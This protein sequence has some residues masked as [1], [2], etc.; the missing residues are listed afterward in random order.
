MLKTV[1]LFSFNSDVVVVDNCK[2][3]AVPERGKYG[4]MKLLQFCENHRPAY[5]GTW[6]KKTTAIRPRNPWSKDN[7]STSRAAWWGSFLQA[8]LLSG[9]SDPL[10]S[11]LLLLSFG[12]LCTQVIYRN[13]ALA[14][15]LE[16]TG[17]R[18]R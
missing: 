16:T 9:V 11:S 17:L 6:N 14:F 1:V 15:L 10:A 7:V 3:D 4:R 2:T 5:W 18:G 12:A 13:G 8:H